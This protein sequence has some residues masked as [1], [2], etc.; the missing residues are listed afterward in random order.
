MFYGEGESLNL[1]LIV[2]NFEADR[3]RYWG[4][5]EQGRKYLALVDQVAKALLRGS[6]ELVQPG[7]TSLGEVPFT[8]EQVQWLVKVEQISARVR[9]RVEIDV[10]WEYCVDTPAMANRCIELARVVIAGRPNE[11]VLRYLRRVSRCYIAG[12]GPECVLLCRGAIENAVKDTF[13]RKKIPLPATREGQSTMKSR[14][15]AAVRLGM[16][17]QQAAD[18]AQVVWTRGNKAAHDD[19]EATRDVLGTITLSMH[20]LAELYAAGPGA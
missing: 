16:M 13:S 2:G 5:D 4:D 17:S 14:L 12:F 18:N 1:D 20:V 11:A 10:A 19:P 7:D 8:W 3:E 15:A 9:E 6:W